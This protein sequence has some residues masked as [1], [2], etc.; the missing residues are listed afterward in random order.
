MSR[1]LIVAAVETELAPFIACQ[2]MTVERW[3]VFG[4]HSVWLSFTGVGAVASAYHILRLA[5][6]LSPDLIIQAGVGGCYEGSGLA[7]GQTVQVVKERLADLGVILDG[8]FTNVF[9]EN[10]ALENPHRFPELD[11][12]EAAGFTVNTGCAPH[13]DGIRKAFHDDNA[14]VETMEGFSLFYV[15]IQTGIRFLQL[16]TISNRVSPDRSSWDIPLSTANLAA[17]LLETLNRL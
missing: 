15:G 8:K 9:P 1:I 16:R 17:A 5:N 13:I 3:C 2:K 7:V 11:Y 6:R 14:A 4:G 12:P 10:R